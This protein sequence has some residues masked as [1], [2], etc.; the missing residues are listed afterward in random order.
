M[1]LSP[2]GSRL[3]SSRTSVYS[4]VFLSVAPLVVCG[5]GHLHTS[6]LGVVYRRFVLV[7]STFSVLV[8]LSFLLRFPLVFFQPDCDVVVCA[9]ELVGRSS[10]T[11]QG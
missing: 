9:R 10:V 4:E 5:L 7:V 2:Y 11:N 1:I 8:S 6:L 3:E